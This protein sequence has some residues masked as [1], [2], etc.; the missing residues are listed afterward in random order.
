[1]PQYGFHLTANNVN[2]HEEVVE[3][4]TLAEA[5]QLAE[6]K[7]QGFRVVRGRCLDN[8]DPETARSD[9]ALESFKG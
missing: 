1:M 5:I 2:G 9:R 3:A 4:D 8:Y 7:H 6:A